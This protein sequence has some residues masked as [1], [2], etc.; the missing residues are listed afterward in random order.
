MSTSLEQ[1][2]NAYFLT[3]QLLFELAV[4]SCVSQANKLGGKTGNAPDEF[5]IGVFI[6]DSMGLDLLG[7][8]GISQ[9]TNHGVSM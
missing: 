7:G 2:A 4:V 3:L 6:D 8:I 5:S 1:L 9:C